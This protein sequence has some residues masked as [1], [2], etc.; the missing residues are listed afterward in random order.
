MSEEGSLRLSAYY[1]R[2][3]TQSVTNSYSPQTNLRF[4]VV[5][6]GDRNKHYTGRWYL[7]LLLSVEWTDVVALVVP[8]EYCENTSTQLIP[9]YKHN[10]LYRPV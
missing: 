4:E 1:Y 7:T 2:Q 8:S 3:R 6:P 9:S 5:K 10:Y